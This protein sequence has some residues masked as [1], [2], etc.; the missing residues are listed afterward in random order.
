[1]WAD[2]RAD[3]QPSNHP[4][5]RPD[6]QHALSLLALQVKEVSAHSPPPRSWA[7]SSRTETITEPEHLEDCA[8]DWATDAAVLWQLSVVC[9]KSGPSPEPKIFPQPFS[10]LK[11]L[12]RENSLVRGREVFHVRSDSFELGAYKTTFIPPEPSMRKV[13]RV[14]LS[15]L[16]RPKS[17]GCERQQTKEKNLFKALDLM[18]VD[19]TGE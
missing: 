9:L 4:S 5:G 12:R 13:G 10:L 19:A 7:F 15:V 1:M 2:S 3:S 14:D 17:M 8:A 6:S 18:T 16:V 11:T